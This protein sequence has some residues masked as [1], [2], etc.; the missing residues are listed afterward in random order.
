MA[1]KRTAT[2]W[3]IMCELLYSGDK[4]TQSPWNSGSQ[5]DTSV[6]I[7]LEYFMGEITVFKILQSNVGYCDIVTTMLS[8]TQCTN[9]LSNNS[10]VPT[11]SKS[12]FYNQPI[13]TSVLIFCA[14]SPSSS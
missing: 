13:Y 9:L 2:Y 14:S 12:V 10:L 3:H 6:D 11:P 5:I 8:G 1:E 4:S 7:E